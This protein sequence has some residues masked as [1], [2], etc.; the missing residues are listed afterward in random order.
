MKNLMQIIVLS[1]W[2]ATYFSSIKNF[3][4]LHI[5]RR[6]QLRLHLSM[7]KSCHEFDHQSQLLDNSIS[8]F[9]N[10]SQLQTEETL[11]AEKKSQIKSSVNQRIK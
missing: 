5:I 8:T 11:S 7:C 4:K 1:C 2:Q 3:T 9:Q 6:I 10:N